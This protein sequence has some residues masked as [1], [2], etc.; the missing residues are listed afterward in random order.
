MILLS[1][2]GHCTQ[3]LAFKILPKVV[4]EIHDPETI[5]DPT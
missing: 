1:T 3:E 2:I 5:Y 4:D